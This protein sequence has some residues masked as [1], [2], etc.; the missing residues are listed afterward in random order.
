MDGSVESESGSGREERV[1]SGSV[2]V[3]VRV[4]V[5]W[6]WGSGSGSESGSPESSPKRDSQTVPRTPKPPNHQNT[7]NQPA[8]RDQETWSKIGEN[9]SNFWREPLQFL[10]PL[11][12]LERFSPIFQ[13]IGENLSN[14]P[15]IGEVLSNFPKI[16]EVLSN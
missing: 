9:L 6:E 10:E 14:F 3:G 16:G 1:S 8:G 11:Q 5:G 2:V 15:K 7:K 12:K 4:G 13:K